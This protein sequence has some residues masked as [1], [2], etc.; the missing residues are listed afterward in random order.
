MS[1]TKPLPNSVQFGY[2][3]LSALQFTA[4]TWKQNYNDIYLIVEAFSQHHGDK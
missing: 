4:L 1:C 2:N 3:L